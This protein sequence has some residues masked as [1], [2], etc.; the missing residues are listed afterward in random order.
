VIVIILE[1]LFLYKI[2]LHTLDVFFSQEDENW[3]F[4]VFK[5]CCKILV[6]IALNLQNAFTKMSILTMLILLI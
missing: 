3:F 5:N 2:P 6:G 4:K 1:V